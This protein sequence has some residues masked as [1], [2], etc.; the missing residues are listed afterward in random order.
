MD[1]P[2]LPEMPEAKVV[3]EAFNLV[4][5]AIFGFSFQGAVREPFGTIL[6]TLK[7]AT[8]PITSMDIP[9]GWDVEKGSSDGIQPDPHQ[10]DPPSPPPRSRRCTS[11]AAITTWGA[12]SC[13][14]PWRGSTSSTCLRT[15]APTVCTS[16]PEPEPGPAYHLP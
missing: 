13:P 1:I 10:P 2:F 12:A 5:G 14:P 8:V 6:A 15:P 9:S 4:V 7:K 16:C 3:D 11:T